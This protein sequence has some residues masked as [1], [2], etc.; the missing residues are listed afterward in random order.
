MNRILEEA[1]R[2]HAAGWGVHWLYPKSKRPVGSWSSDARADWPTLERTFRPDYNLG[3][4]LGKASSLSAGFLACLDCDVKSEKPEHET[5]M[6][7]ALEKVYSFAKY[8]GQ[9]TV[10]SGRGHGSRH[11]YGVTAE[12]VAQR[13]IARSV[14]EVKAKIPSAGTPSAHEI[15]VLSVEELG[16]GIRLRPAWEIAL[17]GAGRQMALPPSIHPD[18]GREYQWALGCELDVSRPL[19]R[20]D[21]PLGVLEAP[22]GATR[23]PSSALPWVVTDVDWLDDPRATPK[24]INLVFDADG[25]ADQSAALLAACLAMLKAGFSRD[26]ILTTLTDPEFF[27][28]ECAYRHAGGVVHLRHRLRAAAWL[29]RHTLAKAVRARSLLDDFEAQPI[30]GE[31]VPVETLSEADALK[32]AEELVEGGEESWFLKLERGGQGRVKSTLLNL[33]SIL[34]H[35]VGE[36]IFR[37]N[38][39]TLRKVFGVETPWGNAVGDEIQDKDLVKIKAWVAKNY[40]VEPALNLISEAVTLLSDR[41]AFHPVQD[42]L[43]GL[44]WDGEPRIDTWLAHYLSATGPEPYL[45][46]VSRKIL[47]AMVARVLDPGHHFDCVLILEGPQGIG[48]ST[49]IRRLVTDEW[50]SDAHIDIREKD[51]VLA[52]TGIW[53]IELGELSSLKKSDVDQLKEFISRRFDRIRLPYGALT[54]LFP[55]QCV[56]IGTTNSVEYLRDISGNRR[57]WPVEVGACD[58]DAITRD[59]DQLFAEARWYYEIGEPL[60]LDNAEA[61][62]GSRQEQEKRMVSDILEDVLAKEFEKVRALPKA[63]RAF[64]PDQFTMAEL[65]SE[66]GPLAGKLSHTGEQ[67]RVGRCLVRI[68]YRSK[69]L[70]D[71]DRRSIRR[72]VR[73]T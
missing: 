54:E 10:Y 46:A 47:C 63:D 18:T 50:F 17:Y 69:V 49:S 13:V 44:E 59:R 41:H 25:M 30:P 15:R 35:G 58:W 36:N 43:R 11:I 39:F 32:Q 61:A 72:W 62:A 23:K 48:K 37:R 73:A 65:F 16:A 5:E 22:T 68:G 71:N 14:E 1:R 66:T 21:T 56:F 33:A 28:G 19:M 29:E 20:L 67:T 6:L 9:P 34:T 42:Y 38:L 8:A 51:A 53:A 7:A 4:R 26:E 52:M 24:I 27:L 60:Y 40:G 64:D 70:K 57:F 3:V 55:R 12:P 45:S 2:L 31:L